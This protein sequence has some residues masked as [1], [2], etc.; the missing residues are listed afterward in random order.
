MANPSE[1]A[2][3]RRLFDFKYEEIEELLAGLPAAA[4]TWK[5]FES[6]PWQ[7]PAGSIGWL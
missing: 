2:T 6:S 1:L 5:P 7:G 4:L 3:Y